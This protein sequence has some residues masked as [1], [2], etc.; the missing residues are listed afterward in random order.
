MPGPDTWRDEDGIRACSFCGS[1]APADFL[2]LV[3]DGAEV[4]PTDKA[5]KAYVRHED[6]PR[7]MTKV[8]FQHFS[9][10]DQERFIALHN[11]RVM[12]IGYPGHF[13]VRPFFAGRADG[14]DAMRWALGVEDD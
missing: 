2:R 4:G 13:Y 14:I 5:Y 12:K 6:L 3:A 9:A 8:Y 11:D 7:R 1:L 10:E